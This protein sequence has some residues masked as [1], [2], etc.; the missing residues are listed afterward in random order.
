MKKER[1]A[2]F[3]LLGCCMALVCSWIPIFWE[4]VISP[5][6]RVK[7]SFFWVSK[8]FRIEEKCCTK[9]LVTNY[10]PMTCNVPQGH[11]IQLYY[12][13]SLKSQKTELAQVR[14]QWQALVMM[15]LWFLYQHGYSKIVESDFV[16]VCG[17]GGGGAGMCSH[18]FSRTF[19]HNL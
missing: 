14:F 8:T 16:C 13:R 10:Q 4:N 7:K 12:A 9:T 17:G 1:T 11:R 3:T 15:N 19:L 18:T 2:A 6:S 5:I